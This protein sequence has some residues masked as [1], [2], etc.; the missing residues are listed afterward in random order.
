[1]VYQDWILT[2]LQWKPPFNAIVHNSF[3]ANEDLSTIFVFV[4]TPPHEAENS[5]VRILA[6][7]F[8]WLQTS[9]ISIWYI[10]CIYNITIWLEEQL[11]AFLLMK[12]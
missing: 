8:L 3:F 11:S 5:G 2:Q 9:D 4:V 1:M 12:P 7:L 6:L 10:W